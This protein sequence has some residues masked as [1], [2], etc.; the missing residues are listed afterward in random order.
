MGNSKT[1]FN[2]NIELKKMADRVENQ[3]DFKKARL[4]EKNN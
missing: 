4:E 3:E 1:I 2:N